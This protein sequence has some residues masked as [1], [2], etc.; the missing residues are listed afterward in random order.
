M[1]PPHKRQRLSWAKSAEST[2]DVDLQ[3][4]RA[5]NDQKLKSLFE[6]IFKKYGKDFSD[7]GDEIDLRTGEI[8]V[9]KG[10]VQRMEHE[11]DT[12]ELT[13]E[14]LEEE[15]P[16]D[17]HRTTD[18]GN[19]AFMFQKAGKAILDGNE[20][21]ETGP[22]RSISP[23]N[24][25]PPTIH[26]PTDP[27]WQAP[28]IDANFWTPLRKAIP[29]PVHETP[30]TQRSKSPPTAKS[31]WAVPSPG[32]SRGSTSKK[33]S[34]SGS[35]KTSTVRSKP[36]RK[37]PIKLD[38]SFA[39]I[40]RDDS[41]SDD[42]LQDDSLPSS[43]RSKKVPG[44]T[45]VSVTPKALDVISNNIT[46]NGRKR[47]DKAGE[48]EI[49]ETSEKVE[50]STP[51]PDTPQLLSSSPVMTYETPTHTRYPVNFDSPSI[52]K[53][54]EVILTPDEVKVIVKFKCQS[55]NNLCMGDM[56][57]H[58]QGRTLEDLLNWA[59][60]HS[61]LFL[62]NRFVST[63]GW[64]TEDLEKLDGFADESGIWWRDI[65]MKLPHRSRREIE[66]QMIRIWSERIVDEPKEKIEEDD[67]VT[68]LPATEREQSQAPHSDGTD[69]A[70]KADDVVS[71]NNLEDDGEVI[72]MPTTEREYSQSSHPDKIESVLGTGDVMSNNDL[73]DFS[74]EEL[75]N[76]WSS[77]SAIGVRPPISMPYNEVIAASLL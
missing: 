20:D 44:R 7:I 1:E 43:I 60:H 54:E 77:I 37:T 9:N 19:T 39:R 42:P 11:D 28:E 18:D 75:D 22:V 17:E 74:E 64:S 2:N 52:I 23:D 14:E 27:K 70:L 25:H 53:P 76:D 10:H 24:Q 35:K 38:W 66:K 34:V 55:P 31:V 59:D 29:L 68:E 12:G 72:E 26:K 50:E 15:I 13:E 57:K 30:H 32:R 5:Q 65:Q 61:L 3:I 8:V 21:M 51:V 49:I 63:A 69:P 16:P 67:E 62:S 40:Q 6:G 41:D 73:E 46:D 56:V 71:N 47:D 48:V 4:A 33:Q 36:K 58:L 45:S